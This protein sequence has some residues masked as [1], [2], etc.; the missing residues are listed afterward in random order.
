MR[1]AVASQHVFSVQD[2]LQAFPQ[3]EVRFVDDYVS[4]LQAQSRLASGGGLDGDLG[5]DGSGFGEIALKSQTS[6]SASQ[7]GSS[8]K[9]QQYEYLD[10]KLHSQRYLCQIPHVEPPELEQTNTTLSKAE[11][12]TELVRANNRG[13]ELLEGMQ[14]KC[15]YYWSGW[16]SYKYCFGEGVKQFHQLPARPGVPAYPPVEDPTI[17]GFVLGAIDDGKAKREEETGLQESNTQEKR[18]AMGSLETRG[19]NRYLVQKLSGGTVCDLTGKDRRV[20]V[21]VS[22]CRVSNRRSCILTSQVP[23]Q[24]RIV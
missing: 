4:E 12:E 20:E 19:E 1:V 24:C 15:V 5:T 11:E 3:Y 22:S 16:W 8:S 17:T 10:M 6:G 13:W 14:D 18:P 21:Q 23:L 2:D 7:S 9:K